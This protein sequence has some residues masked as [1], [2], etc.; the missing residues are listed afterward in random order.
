MSVTCIWKNNILQDVL[1]VFTFCFSH[2]PKAHD[3]SSTDN[4]LPSGPWHGHCGLR[5]L[6]GLASLCASC[7]WA[8]TGT[9]LCLWPGNLCRQTTSLSSK[10]PHPHPM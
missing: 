10:D 3:S 1:E 6:P 8:L 2:A 7:T 9:H 4:Q 5:L